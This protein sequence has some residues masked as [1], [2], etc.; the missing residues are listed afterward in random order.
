MNINEFDYHKNPTEVVKRARRDISFGIFTLEDN[1]EGVD[2]Y[3]YDLDR[4]YVFNYLP[5]SKRKKAGLEKEGGPI[6]EESHEEAH[7]NA[8]EKPKENSKENQNPTENKENQ[9][10]ANT[11]QTGEA[12][13][14]DQANTRNQINQNYNA[15]C[16][17]SPQQ[18]LRFNKLTLSS[19]LEPIPRCKYMNTEG[20]YGRFGRN[21][22]FKYSPPRYNTRSYI[23]DISNLKKTLHASH[24]SESLRRLRQAER[25][26]KNSPPLGMFISARGIRKVDYSPRTKFMGQRYDPM[27]FHYGL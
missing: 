6:K 11:N 24:D 18:K 26:G 27:N 15:H 25:G 12:N 17:T 21:Q 1:E 20:N 13:F 2:K 9:P 4:S 16:Q 23:S 22:R 7:E 14:F 5:S 10:Q 3:H 19:L 8:Q